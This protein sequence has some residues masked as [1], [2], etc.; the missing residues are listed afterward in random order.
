MVK[1]TACVMAGNSEHLTE[2]CIRHHRALGVERFII[3]HMHSE[4]GT[5]AVLAALEESGDDVSVIHCP[6]EHRFSQVQQQAFVDQA[7]RETGADWIIRIDSD[8]RWFVRNGSLKETLAAIPGSC[9]ALQVPRRNI[10]WP[11][12]E[13]VDF[14]RMSSVMTL[15][16]LSL[17][18]YP[19]EVPGTAD[20]P[21]GGIPWVLTKIAPKCVML[22]REDLFFG[23][24]G[25]AVLGG[26]PYGQPVEPVSHPDILIAQLAFTCRAQFER[27][28][29]W[30]EKWSPNTAAARGAGIA[31]HWDRL[32]A[33]HAQGPEAVEDEWMRQFMTPDQ[34]RI[35]VGRDVLVAGSAVFGSL[36]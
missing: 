23:M 7:K 9:S 24:G 29:R 12:P 33:I 26:S 6:P 21:L 22:N 15:D 13:A 25:H 35:L 1:I 8:E 27:K 36:R 2:G 5:P 18:L 34:A 31:W 3:L 19:I 32:A 14:A 10:V 16:G 17:A 28:L 30:M 4:D 11:S 20:D